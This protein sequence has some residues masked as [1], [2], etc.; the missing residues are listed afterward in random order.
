[1]FSSRMSGVFVIFWAVVFWAVVNCHADQG[2]PRPEKPNVV[3]IL[4]DDL[5]W[6]DVKCYDIG[7]PSPMET[8]HVDALAKR[9]VKFWQAYSPAPTCAPS[10]CAIMSGNHPAR[11]QKTHVVGGAPP[12]PNHKA[13]WKVIAPWYSGRMPANE[14]TLAKVLR[15]NGYTTG[16]VGKW[17]M[18]IDHHAFPQPE[19]Q[20]FDWTRSDRGARAS[21]KP[22]RIDG[23]A[24]NTK[25]D[26]FKLDANGF[27]YHANSENALTFLNEQK[28]KPFFLYY[29]TWLVHSPIHTRSKQLLDK[30]CNKLKIDPATLKAKGWAGKG[31][32]NPF[33]CAM[34]EELDYY[35]GK[36]F[37][38]LDNT[39]DPRWPGHKLCENTYV[40]FTSDNGGMEGHPGEVYTDNYPLDKGKINAMEG[41]IRVPLI[42]TGPKAPKNVASDVV[43]N[44]LDFYPTILSLVGAK[45]PE[46][47]NIDGCDLTGLLEKPDAHERV[48]HADGSVRDTMMWHFPNSAAMESAI[49]I[50]GYKLI[51]NY[52]HMG[53][54]RTPELELYELYRTANGKQKRVDI[55][56]A[57]NL[58]G[59][60]PKLTKE[61]NAKLTERL[62]EMQ[63][64]Y[65]YLNPHY[66]RPLAGKDKVC[67]VTSFRVDGRN[68]EISYREK[69]AKVVRAD[70]IYTLNG[71][72]RY[73]EWFR[74][75]AVLAPGCKATAV[76]PKGTTHYVFNLIDENQFLRSYPELPDMGQLRKTKSTY[77][78][79]AL[80][81]KAKAEPTP[82]KGAVRK[83]T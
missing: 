37:D 7:K 24:A 35:V 38:Y 29:A 13:A 5:G 31:Q 33:Y 10:R 20:G 78:A 46:G 1:M 47:K 16:H 75:R 26:K 4:T 55:E 67:D 70:L 68:V 22:S 36:V 82:P 41:G 11:A 30:Y 3:L 52:A 2:P 69:G 18:A 27:P 76:L 51:R 73:E 43:V 77:S 6:Q 65:P 63:A 32:T 71:G 74:I 80:D 49:R 21:M 53:D 44:G 50:G 83:K 12:T 57:H 19:D 81:V 14:V 28:D 56:E 66:R 79:H 54:P 59:K 8:P 40:I 25:G 42:I 9:G 17:H 39:D 62:A 45:I 72:K 60:M 64:S 34:V 58:A 23:F 61:M 15:R 48:K